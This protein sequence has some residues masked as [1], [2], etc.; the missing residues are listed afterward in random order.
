MKPTVAGILLASIFVVAAATAS[1]QD[2]TPQAPIPSRAA[3]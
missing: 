1:A 3:R 2:E